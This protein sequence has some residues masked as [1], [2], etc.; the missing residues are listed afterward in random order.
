MSS[1]IPLS[2]SLYA[3]ISRYCKIHSTNKFINI[4]L[5]FI[6]SLII[7]IPKA[8][9]IPIELQERTDSLFNENNKDTFVKVLK[10]DSS[11]VYYAA[12]F[13]TMPFP[14]DTVKKNLIKI[15]N[16]KKAFDFIEESYILENRDTYLMIA[17]AGPVKSWFLVDF[18]SSN[19]EDVIKYN[20]IKNKDLYLNDQA[21]KQVKGA[22]VVEYNEFNIFWKIKKISNDSS[23]V[24]LV[25]NVDPSVWIPRWLFKLASKIIFPAMLKDFENFIKEQ[26][27]ITD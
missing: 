14:I 19:H 13:K 1:T 9:P 7:S 24:A 5:F 4:L 16:Y 23:R 15:S 27:I 6:L 12:T 8:I 22:F 25:A 18:D 10:N 2:K 21:R 17:K 26:T 20:G 3:I 11:T